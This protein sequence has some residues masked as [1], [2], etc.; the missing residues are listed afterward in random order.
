MPMQVSL[1]QVD[2]VMIECVCID[3]V[4][5]LAFATIMLNT[6]AHSAHIKKKMTKAEF[7]N[8]TKFINNGGPLP[9][10]YM[11]ALYD[12][13]VNDEIKME[14]DGKMWTN[15]DKKGWLIKQGT[16]ICTA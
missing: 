10:E 8:N 14:S 16:S 9:K 6:D 7:L 4:Y 15:A 13:I 11:E 12:K 2:W 3:T 5:L 1:Q